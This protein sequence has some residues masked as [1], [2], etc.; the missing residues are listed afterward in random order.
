VNKHVHRDVKHPTKS[1]PF[2]LINTE[3]AS[4][5]YRRAAP[6]LHRLLTIGCKR[7]WDGFPALPKTGPAILVANHL[8]SF[9]AVIIA[10][11]I[12]YHGR[13]PYFLAKSSLWHVPVLRRL[14][15]AID[16]IPVYRGTNQ[17]SDSLAEARHRLEQGKV[18][19]IFPEGTTT[20]DPKEWPFST[21]TGAA[22]LA[23][24]TGAPVIPFG[25]WGASVICPDNAGPQKGP[26]LLPR[27]W[28][29]F[30]SGEPMDLSRFGTDETDRDA[31][32]ACSTAILTGI[33]EQVARAR[34]E[35]APQLR[36]NP[37]V[38]GYVPPNQAIW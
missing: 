30:R 27:H 35:Q 24:E 36:W 23:M 10:D 31:V 22:R 20:R 4:A 12:L 29:C 3:E 32:R 37:K 38:G 18:V 2:R 17:A 34:G 5:T 25:H 15:R 33:V 9:D 14:L 13:Y 16:Q 21:K 19:F 11:Y 1:A 7:D 26:H 6:W 8:T 28:V